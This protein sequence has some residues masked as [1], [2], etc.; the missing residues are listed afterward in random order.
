M[1]PCTVEY[2]SDVASGVLVSRSFRA[3]LAAV[4]FINLLSQMI[5]D[6]DGEK[7][8]YTYMYVCIFFRRHLILIPEPQ[9]LRTLFGFTRW[10]QSE[11]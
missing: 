3:D 8:Q 1:Y 2:I 9:K 4:F 7:A 11:R 10:E 6:A 5:P